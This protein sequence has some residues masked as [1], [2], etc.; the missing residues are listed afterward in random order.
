VPGSCVLGHESS[1]FIQVGEIVVYM[2]FVKNFLCVFSVWSLRLDYF[3]P[4]LLQ[5]FPISKVLKKVVCS[6]KQFKR[7]F[8]KIM[9]SH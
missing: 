6:R 1:G 3:R 2:T 8:V 7:E 4:L 9:Q 5:S